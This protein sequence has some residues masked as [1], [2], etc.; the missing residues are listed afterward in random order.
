M[1]KKILKKIEHHY[2]STL[3]SKVQ[4]QK[5]VG[6]FPFPTEQKAEQKC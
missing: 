5:N 6:I 1:E 3:E 4:V 2:F